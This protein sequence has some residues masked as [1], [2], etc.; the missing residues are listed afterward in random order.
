MAAAVLGAHALLGALLWSTQIWRD[1][2][3][4]PQDAR[5]L[6]LQ[7]PR[8]PEERLA[9]PP[10]AVAERTFRAPPRREPEAIAAPALP[11]AE[12]GATVPL[13]NTPFERTEPTLSAPAPAASAPPLKLDLPRDRQAAW[14]QR[15]PALDDPRAN[16]GRRTLESSIAAAL[17]GDI[18]LPILEERLA[19]GSVRFRRGSACVIARPNR[20]QTLDPFNAGFSPKPRPVEPC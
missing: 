7:W 17:G 3:P 16:S 19:D 5:P 4:A 14:R 2:H 12:P 9:E 20:A 6:W 13:P 8:L 15:N 11:P 10:R 1:R 18:G